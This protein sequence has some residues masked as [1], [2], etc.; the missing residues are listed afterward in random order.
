M[1]REQSSIGSSIYYG[2]R[3]ADNGVGA[4]LGTSTLEKVLVYDFDFST[5]PTT[6]ANDAV[7]PVIPAGAQIVSATL[8][9]ASVFTAGTALDVGVSQTNGTV[10]NANGL[11]AAASINPGVYVGA[12]ALIGASVGANDAQI[13]VSDGV[14]TSAA[15]KGTLYVKVLLPG[16]VV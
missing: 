16:S 10:I 6:D 2:P 4:A 13:T 15:G 12:G 11:V 9:V 8:E 7:I 5:F 3:T 14:G 1:A